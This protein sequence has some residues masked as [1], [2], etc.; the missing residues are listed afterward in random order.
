MENKWNA[1]ITMTRGTDDISRSIDGTPAGFR[2]VKET[3]RDALSF[4]DYAEERIELLRDS[5]D[6]LDT[7]GAWVTFFFKALG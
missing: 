7:D 4:T 2:A 5:G 3:F 1:I 6:D